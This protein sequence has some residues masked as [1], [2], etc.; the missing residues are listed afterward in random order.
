M[1]MPTIRPQGTLWVRT[2]ALENE[3]LRRISLGETMSSICR[4][5]HM[6]NP[7]VV[8]HW[9][10]TDPLFAEKLKDARDVGFDAIAEGI[11]D[12]A[13]DRSKDKYTDKLGNRVLD[14][15]VV[16]RSKLRVWARLELLKKW[17]PER[18]GD[19][20]KMNLGG[21]KD[22]PIRVIPA[23]VSAEEAATQYLEMV[24]AAKR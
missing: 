11:L 18:Y 4:D 13:D 15:E 9:R 16:Q 14:P 1:N 21:Q 22:N 12:I 5:A 6:P 7:A 23:N 8:A 10:K 17:S 20:V 2:D 19:M 24:K 3:I